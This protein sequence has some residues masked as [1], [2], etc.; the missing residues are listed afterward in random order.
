MSG[1]VSRVIRGMSKRSLHDGILLGIACA[2]L[3][4]SCTSDPQ[5]PAG[6]GLSPKAVEASTSVTSLN[7][8]STPASAAVISA[9]TASEGMPQQTVRPVAAAEESKAPAPAVSPQGS[10]QGTRRNVASEQAVARSVQQPSVTSLPAASSRNARC[11]DGTVSP[12]WYPVH[13]PR[14]CRGAWV[15]RYSRR[16]RGRQFSSTQTVRTSQ[17]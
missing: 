16:D 10:A 9:P 7:A 11:C 4:V 6:S 12:S 5:P 17:S 2:S 1:S 15:T 8:A 14:S 13:Q 3:T